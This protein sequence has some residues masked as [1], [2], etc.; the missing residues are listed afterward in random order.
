VAAAAVVGSVALWRPP[1]E[2]KIA[3]VGTPPGVSQPAGATVPAVRVEK[4]AEA[5]LPPTAPAPVARNEAVSAG[6]GGGGGLGGARFT[7]AKSFAFDYSITPEGR[8][9]FVPTATGFLTVSVNNGGSARVILASRP[10]QGGSTVEVPLPGDSISATIL[11]TARLT[12]P[13]EAAGTVGGMA[14]A[15]D[16]TSG[17]KTDPNPSPDSRLVAVVP[18][19][20]H[21]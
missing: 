6:G 8:L 3:E 19:P 21:P 16:P 13:Q 15:T 5:P 1:A 10:T 9:K 20:P 12:A 18:I 4:T 7:A 17:T 2:Q 14:A 11:F